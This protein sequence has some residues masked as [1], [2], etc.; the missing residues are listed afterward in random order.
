[1]LGE[2]MP[3]PMFGSVSMGVIKGDMIMDLMNLIILGYL[4]MSQSL[5]VQIGERSLIGLLL[6]VVTREMIGVGLG[7]QF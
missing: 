4:N 7:A 6:N 1:V 3:A 2:P 5:G